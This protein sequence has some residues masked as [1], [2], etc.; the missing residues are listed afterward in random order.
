MEKSIST[1]EARSASDMRERGLSAAWRSDMRHKFSLAFV[2]AFAVFPLGSAIAQVGESGYSLPLAL[3][4]KAATKAIAT[5]A[6]N[7]YP[8]SAVVVDPSGV[9]KLEAK[10]DHSTIHTTTSAFRKA[11]TV[12]TFGPIFR[13]DASSA[14]AALVAK[15][16][17]GA[18]LATL[19]D[20]ALLAGG[21]AIKARD[22]VV[23]ALGVAGSP[24][25]DKDE[26][27]AQAGVAS[28]KDDLA[29]S[30]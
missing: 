28:I 11:Y 10:G 23:S 15:N 3:A 30:R 7:G 25:G 17:N 4:V 29:S 20:I 21:V 18:A 22:E 19:P 14:F 26:A 6:S 8:V 2:A 13:F 9:I 27:C 12:V 16:P 1:P 5:C 24:G